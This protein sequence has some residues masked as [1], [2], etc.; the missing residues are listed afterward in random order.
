MS[1]CPNVIRNYATPQTRGTSIAKYYRINDNFIL[2][3]CACVSDSGLCK[4]N[5]QLHE[6]LNLISYAPL[7]NPS[8]PEFSFKF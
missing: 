2:S 1:V 8:T 3:W 5:N 4:R 7:F 6:A